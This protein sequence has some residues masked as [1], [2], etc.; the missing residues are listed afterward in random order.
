MF[1]D[2]VKIHVKAGDGG[3]GC[4]SFRR[5]AHVPRGGPDGGDGGDGGSVYLVGDEGLLTLLDLRHRRQL[6][7]RRGGHGGPKNKSGRRGQDVEYRVPLGT[8]VSDDQGV[9]GEVMR[10]GERL[11]VARGGRGG[12]G[13]QHFA[14]ST[15]RAPR[16]ADPGEPG[17]ERD[18]ILEL[19]LIADIGLVGQPNAGKSTLLSALTDAHPKIAPYPFTTVH[20]NLGVAAW[21]GQGWRQLVL[22]DIPGLIEGAHRGQGLGHRFLRHIERT[23][24]LIHLVAL[25][26]GGNSP[27][28][29]C[30]QYALVSNELA[31]YSPRLAAKPRLVAINKID[32]AP[33]LDREAIAACF[34]ARGV[35]NV[36]FI[37]A[38][39]GEGTEELLKAATLHL[40]DLDD[41]HF[42]EN[43]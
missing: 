22:A 20:P 32:L 2:Y 23:R 10:H 17:E 35:N 7:A 30:E 34:R 43:H 18:L 28:S 16:R 13:N 31:R 24:V 3:D 5:E 21:P 39:S 40:T 29:L 33:Q 4:V 25:G 19:K 15:N 38:Q 6:R 14:S 41:E 42:D 12:R 37:S 8:V 27:E 26:L 36:W 9:I 1:V 11:L